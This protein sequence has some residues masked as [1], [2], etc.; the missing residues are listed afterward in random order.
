MLGLMLTIVDKNVNCKLVLLNCFYCVQMLILL[1]AV[2]DHICGR[3]VHN[4]AA[5][6]G[7]HCEAVPHHAYVLV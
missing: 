7:E 1:K 3:E 5:G 4:Y 2:P 6:D